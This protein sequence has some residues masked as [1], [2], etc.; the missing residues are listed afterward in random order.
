MQEVIQHFSE[1]FRLDKPGWTFPGWGCCAF[2]KKSADMAEDVVDCGGVSIG[3]SLEPVKSTAHSRFD[4]VCRGTWLAEC[5][6]AHPE[7]DFIRQARKM[8][9]MSE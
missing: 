9:S 5:S 4:H 1:L 3:A 6:L 8:T 7:G 2:G